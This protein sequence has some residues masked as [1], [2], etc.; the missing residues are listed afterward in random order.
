MKRIDPTA[1]RIEHEGRLGPVSGTIDAPRRDLR[2]RKPW[3]APRV[4][5]YGDLRGLTL[6]GSPTDVGDSQFPNTRI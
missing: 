2:P 6:G 4:R 3:T 5:S 1:A